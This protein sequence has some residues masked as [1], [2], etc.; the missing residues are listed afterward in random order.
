MAAEMGVLGGMSFVHQKY[1][2][3]LGN[4][5]ESCIIIQTDKKNI[6]D[7]DQCSWSTPFSSQG[8]D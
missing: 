6:T 3:I 2:Q 5:H 1:H 8:I 4:D 7:A